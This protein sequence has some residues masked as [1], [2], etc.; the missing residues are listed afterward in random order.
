MLE[1]LVETTNAALDV[2]IET[3]NAALS[4]VLSKSLEIRTE[5]PRLL[6][7]S[8]EF[9]KPKFVSRQASNFIW[10]MCN[11]SE[12]LHEPSIAYNGRLLIPDGIITRFIVKT[13]KKLYCMAKI[14]F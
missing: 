9:N 10:E 13:N 5:E 3:T 12:I 8:I 11:V 14:Q 2:L 6:I 7:Q 4:G 1:V